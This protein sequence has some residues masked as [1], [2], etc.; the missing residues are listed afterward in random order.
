MPVWADSDSNDPWTSF[1]NIESAIEI[2]ASQIP[3]SYTELRKD[4]GAKDAN[5][6]QSNKLSI[7]ESGAQL[8]A[9]TDSIELSSDNLPLIPTRSSAVLFRDNLQTKPI[10][11]LKA[12]FNPPDPVTHTFADLRFKQDDS[13]WFMQSS[14]KASARLSGW[15]DS[16]SLYT[17]SITYH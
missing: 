2:Q 10:Y 5:T 12:E 14:Q 4:E 11:W 7:N 13:P 3:S 15:K 16:N 1:G 8:T 6:H 17:A 9:S